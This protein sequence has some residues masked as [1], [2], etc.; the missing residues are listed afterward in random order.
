MDDVPYLSLL[1]AVPAGGAAVVAAIPK[2]QPALARA[3][4]IGVSLA[5]AVVAGALVA[6]F[7]RGTAGFQFVEDTEWISS[8]G[9]SYL[10]AVDGISIFMVALTAL[11]FPVALIASAKIE[12]RVHLYFALML[13]LEA[14]IMGVFVGID[15]FLF[16]IFWEAV[17][18][19]MYFLVGIWG[20]DRRVYA[21][22]KFFLYTALGS[23]FLLA[24]IL[25]LAF[26]HAAAPGN[27]LTFDLRTLIAWDGLSPD[28]ARWLFV[29]FFASFAVKVPLFP[30]HT[31]LPDAHVEA[32]TAGSVL[33]AG[34]FLK[35]GAYGFLRFSLA[36]FPQAS[37]DFA[38]L[39]L[40][41]ATI[42]IVYGAVVAAVQEDLKKL[43]AYSSV[44]HLGF[45]VLG[46]FAL[47]TPGL[48]GGVFTMISHGLTTGALFLLVGILYDRRHTRDIAAFGG[49]WK[50]APKLGGVF[51]AVTFASIGL[52]GM[53]GFVGEFLALLGT[54][55]VQRPYA[56]V[57]TVGVILAAVYML[58]G[59]QRVFTGEPTGENAA[60]ADVDRRE[61]LTLA[62][63]LGLSL[64]LGVYPQ[65]VLERVEPTVRALITHVE[66]RSDYTAPGVSER[67]AGEDE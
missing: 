24:G 58:W 22:L 56:I 45:V 67:V 51:L 13:V 41:L 60:I 33:L 50:A 49:L 34:I 10:L 2:D 7:D 53:S 19:P 25:T 14:G 6:D 36:L 39:L 16:F 52:P 46:T 5:V 21:A 3:W 32:P 20:Y 27:D 4:A 31:W 30:L 23:A 55:V 37:V 65:P 28:T 42:G 62:P 1:I 38:P 29:A 40:T 66:E 17:L 44:A 59:F 64:F 57:S 61:M 47:T 9:I 8:L 11:L 18:I 12:R 35:L 26:L 15:L 43:V 63:L 54:F 48:Q